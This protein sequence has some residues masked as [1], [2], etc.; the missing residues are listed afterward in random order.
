M[1][2]EN[3]LKQE[4][5]FEL[6]KE[7]DQWLT[8][9]PKCDRLDK[10][11]VNNDTGQFKCFCCDFKGNA[12]TLLK[13][14]TPSNTDVIWDKLKQYGLGDSDAPGKAKKHKPPIKADGYRHATAQ[15]L[16]QLAAAKNV[17]VRAL[18]KLG[19]LVDRQKPDIAIL[20]MHRRDTKRPVGGIRVRLD[21]KPCWYIDPDGKVTDSDGPGHKPVKYP[22][23]KD[24][25]VGILG[26][27]WLEEEN[28]NTVILTEGFKDMLAAIDA[29]YVATTFGGCGSFSDDCLWAF[30]GKTVIVVFDCDVAG[31]KHAPRQAERLYLDA[32]EVLV[33]PNWTEV[34][35]TGGEDVHDY[36][37][38]REIT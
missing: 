14:L 8:R 13:E 38:E 36:L 31:Q 29:G 20:P 6:R 10:M 5:G 24:G 18:S 15:E 30:E 11:S 35:P 12:Y 1:S 3:F 9:C 37:T 25:L 19:V 4:L 17:S 2:V 33:V 23:V 21:G 26:A 16:A 28:C 27:K 32:K 34:K 22:M 7:G